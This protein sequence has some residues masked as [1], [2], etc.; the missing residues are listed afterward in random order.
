MMY[1]ENEAVFTNTQYWT[2]LAVGQPWVH[3]GNHFRQ[4]LTYI[5]ATE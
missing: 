5:T 2:G 1:G 4:Q 3:W